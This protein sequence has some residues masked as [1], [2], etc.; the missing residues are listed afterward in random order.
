M[1]RITELATHAPV[2]VVNHETAAGTDA[3]LVAGASGVIGRREPA[4]C[5]VRAVRSVAAGAEVA[6]CG[7]TATSA[8]EPA[9]APGYNLSDRESQVLRQIS[10]GLTHGQIATRL[11]ISPHTVDTYVKR[12]RT[13]LGVGN[14]A[15]LTR[16]ALLG[17]PTAEQAPGRHPETSCGDA[18][19]PEL[20]TQAAV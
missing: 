2:L 5:I 16:V 17:R 14:K 9:A 12:I 3:Y 1:R 10:R 4:D 11:G 15:E 18:Y 20:V 13:K 7:C 8:P 19:F 6:P